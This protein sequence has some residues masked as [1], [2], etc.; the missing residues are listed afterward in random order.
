VTMPHDQSAESAQ[1]ARSAGYAPAPV[2]PNR[3][4]TRQDRTDDLKRARA[5]AQL[6]RIAFPQLEQLRI[7]LSFIDPSSISP[8]SQVHTLYPPARAFFTYRCPHSDCDGE[9]ELTDI[10]RM[11]VS[12]GTHEA[13]GSLL[14][15]GA[16]PGEKSSKRTCELRVAYTVTARVS[17]GG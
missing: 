13:H 10:I 15:A 3:T 5:A 1:S 7:E 17:T 12:C 9:F 14:C 6:L 16:R 4:V 8:A 2:L 11:A